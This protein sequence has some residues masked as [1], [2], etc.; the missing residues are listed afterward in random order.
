MAAITYAILNICQAGQNLVSGTKL[1][2]GTNT[3][4]T[5]TLKRFGISVRFVDLRD[6]AAIEAAIDAN[7]RLVFTES[8]GNPDGNLDD[9]DA[10]AAVAH[11]HGLP[12]VV[13]NT[14]LPPPLFDPFAHGADVIVYSLT[15]M[16]GGH[17][18]SV[19]GCVIEKGDFPWNNGRFPEIAGPDAAYHGVDFWA[20]FGGHAEAVAPGLAYVLKMRCGL[21][22]DTGACLSP[23]NA[24]QLLLG[25]ETLPLRARAHCANAQA[26]AEFLA[27]HELVEWVRYPGLANHPDHQRAVALL[28]EGKGAVFGFGITGGRAAGERFIDAVKLCSHL[29]NILDAKTLV[30]HPASTTHQQLSAAEQQK[31]GVR[32]EMVR[33]SVG[34][35]HLDDIIADLDQALRA[36]QG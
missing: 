28:P 21:M 33:I 7:T 34:L 32:P 18:T 22:R 10:I 15:K 17:G 19:G 6:S 36:S 24:Q 12:L 3:L 2:G 4:F 9:L 11:R 23:F 27:G 35:E 8:M 31:A 5:Y 14:V 13:D 26:V 29:A 16:V 25:L 20:A 1:Y 30:I